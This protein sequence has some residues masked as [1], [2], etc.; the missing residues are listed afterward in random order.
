MSTQIYKKCDNWCWVK[1]SGMSLPAASCC[2][3]C[4]CCWC[5]CSVVWFFTLISWCVV[6]FNRCTWSCRIYGTNI[7]L[8]KLILHK[9][10]CSSISRNASSK[11]TH[12]TASYQPKLITQQVTV[13]SLCCYRSRQPNCR[14]LGETLCNSR[15]TCRVPPFSAQSFLW[16]PP[17]L[18]LST[19]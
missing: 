5:C 18:R 1:I 6:W 8:T 7:D 11:E 13:E 2:W 14:R 10:Q 16:P 17:Q 9:L 19:R 4:C 12:G 3:W 15:Y